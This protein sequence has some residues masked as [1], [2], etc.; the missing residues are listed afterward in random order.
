[1]MAVGLSSLG[2]EPPGG[3]HARSSPHIRMNVYAYA[4]VRTTHARTVMLMEVKAG[5][6]GSNATGAGPPAAAVPLAGE[7][8][9]VGSGGC[10][11][12]C[13]VRPCVSVLVQPDQKTNTRP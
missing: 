9:R 3:S 6:Y 4:L 8:G 10:V 13:G 11:L 5:R 12:L 2:P 7:G 1:M